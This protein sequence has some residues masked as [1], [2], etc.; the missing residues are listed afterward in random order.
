[1]KRLVLPDT[2]LP[3]SRLSFGTASLHRVP[4]S[5]GRQALLAEAAALGFSH[6]DASP[7]YGFG[8]AE[9]ELGAFLRGRGDEVTV[10]TKVGLYAPG[11]RT[12]CALLAWG[13][14]AGGRLLPALSRAVV[15]WSVAAA[16]RSLAQ[17][18][19]TLGRERVDVLFLH[20]PAP[21]LLDAEEFLSWLAQRRRS[22]SLRHWGLAGPLRRFPAWTRHPFAEIL[23]VPD[24]DLPD[25]VRAEREPQISYGALASAHDGRSAPTALRDALARNPGGSLLVSTRR[26][27][28]LR[29]LV[30]AAE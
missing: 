14:K 11:G 4:T 29:E 24:A 7:Y 10:A 6:F 28:H 9:H 13:R 17:S 8:V 2:D 19:R 27:E 18:L 20:E 15:D 3:V 30:R 22:G 12:A 26:P 25:L 23:Q 1:V 5:R 16:E 21:G